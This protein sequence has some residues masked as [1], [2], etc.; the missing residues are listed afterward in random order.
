MVLDGDGRAGGGQL[1]DR[2]TAAQKATYLTVHW[3]CL[4][5]RR[6]W[7]GEACDER[8][9]WGP[10]AEVRRD[11]PVGKRTSLHTGRKRPRRDAA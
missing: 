6:E 9:R 4:H 7:Q 3:C 11:R 2:R 5:G 10:F 1:N 8:T